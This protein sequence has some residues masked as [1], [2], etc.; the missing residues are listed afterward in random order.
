MKPIIHTAN[1]WRQILPIGSSKS[2]PMGDDNGASAQ[3][4]V[5]KHL[6]IDRDGNCLEKKLKLVSGCIVQY[7]TTLYYPR[8]SAGDGCNRSTRG[9]M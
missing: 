4:A 3:S 5:K 2:R 7:S 8:S 9:N 1:L 6:A